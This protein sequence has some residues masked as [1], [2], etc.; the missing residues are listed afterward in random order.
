MKCRFSKNCKQ[1]KKYQIMANS[2]SNLLFA[3]AEI[4][5]TKIEVLNKKIIYLKG[6]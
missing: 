2:Q 1:G 5:I 4:F 6:S 3:G